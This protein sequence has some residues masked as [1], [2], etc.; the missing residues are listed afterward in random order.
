MAYTSSEAQIA[1]DIYNYL[2]FFPGHRF[3]RYGQQ[4]PMPSFTALSSPTLKAMFA[5][6]RSRYLNRARHRVHFWH[7]ESG[8]DVAQLDRIQGGST[9]LH[10]TYYGLTDDT[11]S[12]PEY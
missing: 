3:I 8:Y 10:G 2:A 4:A 6:Y 9:I 11:L 12:R 5:E 7:R 1:L